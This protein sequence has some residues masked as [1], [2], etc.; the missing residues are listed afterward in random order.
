MQNQLKKQ[1]ENIVY[2][3]SKLNQVSGLALPD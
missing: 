2:L 3:K 1:S